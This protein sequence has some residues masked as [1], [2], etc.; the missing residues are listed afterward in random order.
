MRQ[1]GHTH[2]STTV[3]PPISPLLLSGHLLRLA[4]EADSAGFYGTADYLLRLASDVLD[5][6]AAIRLC[7][8]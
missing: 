5:E 3:E 6:P 2:A 1:P 7:T 4:K 8:A